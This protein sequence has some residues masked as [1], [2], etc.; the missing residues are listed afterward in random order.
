MNNNIELREVVVG[1]QNNENKSVTERIQT[2]L[3]GLHIQYHNLRTFHWNI[4]GPHFF[5]LHARFEELYNDISAKVD[6]SAERILAIGGK[7]GMAL[8]DYT[9]F[10]SLSDGS[11]LTGA[12]EMVLKVLEGNEILIKDIKQLVNVA[13]ESGDDG[14]ADLFTGYIADFQKTNWML[15]A[16]LA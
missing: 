12:E 4:T 16:F 9:R 7:P 1:V 13:S 6:E 10:S 5:T 11:E 14:T 3:A 15:K 2:V 8:N